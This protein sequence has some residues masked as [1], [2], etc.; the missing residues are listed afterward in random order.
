[1]MTG[2]NN[3]T[4]QNGT[5]KSNATS[6]LLFTQNGAGN[7]T[8]SSV[9]ADGIGNSPLAKTGTGTLTLAGNNTYTGATT[10]RGGILNLT[11]SLALQNSALDTTNSVPGTASAG[12]KTSLT[13]LTLGGLTGSKDLA[14]LFTTSNGGYSSVGNLTLNPSTGVDNL[15]AGSIS[16]GTANLTLIKNGNG[17]QTLSGNST[18]AGL[19]ISAGSMVLK[20]GTLNATGNG[21]FRLGGNSS[22]SFTIDGGT[23]LTSGNTQVGGDVSGGKGLL[24]INNGTWTNSVGATYLGL[25]FGGNGTIMNVNGG[26]VSSAN[27]I[28]IGSGGNTTATLNLNGGT[29]SVARLFNGN[30][31]TAIVNLNGGILK[32]T[33][34]SGNFTAISRNGTMTPL[35][36]LAG[37][38]VLDTNGFDISVLSPLVAGSPSGGLTKT[39]NGTLTLSGNNTYTGVTTLRAG[40]LSVST[41]GDGGVLGN[42][43]Q[44]TSAASNL[45]FAGGGLSYT[46][47]N[48]SS[49]RSFTL[50][51]TDNTTNTIGVSTLGTTLTL[52]GNLPNTNN[53]NSGL[54]QKGGNGTLVLDPGAGVNYTL[55]SLSANGG[56]LT[57]KS[58]NFTTT[59][60]DMTILN[61][62]TLYNFAIGAGARNGGTLVVDGATLNVSTGSLKPGAN[63]NGNL[64]IVSGTVTAPQIWVGHG[65]SSVATQSGGDV[66]TVNLSHSDSGSG[67]YTM[68]G[69]NL[70]VRSIYNSSSGANGTF[71]FAMNGGTLRAREGT[72]NLM[73][74]GGNLTRPQLA[75]HLGSTGARID[76][77]LSNATIQRPLENMSGQ[78]GTLTKIGTNT[79]TLSA[80]NTYTG[81]TT[82]SAGT[83]QIDGNNSGSGAVNIASG[84][85]LGGSG[86]V[87]GHVTV[88]PGGFVAPGAGGIGTLTLASATLS[89]TYQ[90]ELTSTAS[91]LLVVQVLTVDSSTNIVFS[92]APTAD[93]YTIATYGGDMIGT[94]PAITPPSD[95]QLDTATRGVIKLVRNPPTLLANTSLISPPSS[96]TDYVITGNVTITNDVTL[97]ELNSLFIKTATGAS[98][99]NLGT[100]KTAVINSGYLTMTG[101]NNFTIQNGTLKSGANSGFPNSR[102]VVTQDGTGTFTVSSVIANG[103]GNSTLT[104]AGSGTLTLAGAN[105]YTGETTISGGILNLTNSLALQNSPLDA[106][107]SVSGSA[108]A[109]LKTTVSTLTLG[110]LT[111]HKNFASLFTTIGGGY[112]GVTA[113]TL[114][115]GDGVDNTY[116]GI[117]AN[118][119][120][121]MRLIKSGNG[122]LALL[123]SNTYTGNTTISSGILSVEEDKNLGSSG[124]IV[125]A[126]GTLQ[127]VGER[128]FSSTRAV[129]LLANS[130]I[131]VSN[132]VAATTL[133]GT[134]T[135]SANLT[136]TKT[137]SGTL[138]LSG[139]NTS[140]TSTTIVSGGF[141][142]VNGTSIAD[143]GRLVISGGKVNL[144]GNE[145]VG[146]LYFYR[147]PQSGNFTYNATNSSAYFT[148]T[149]NLRVTGTGA[150]LIA[151]TSQ[152]VTVLKNTEK[153]IDLA[154]TLGGNKTYTIVS[155]PANGSLTG[156]PPNMTYHP[157]G[158]YTGP[159]RFT[160]KVNNGDLDSLPATV[161]ITVEESGGIVGT[162]GTTGNYTAGGTNYKVHT[163]TSNG[164]FEVANGGNVRYLVVGGG[165]GGGSA[166]ASEKSGAGGGGGGGGFLTGNL[167]IAP[168]AYPV[169]V[170]AGGAAGSAGFQVAGSSGG[171]SAFA[172]FA[173]AMGGG[174]GAS[175]T[176]S[177][178]IGGSGGG[179]SWGTFPTGGNGTDS[180][181]Y[182]GGNG[183]NASRGYPAGGGGG[184]GGVGGYPS[185]GDNGGRGGVGLSST[186][187]GSELYYADGGGGG[188]YVNGQGGVG[189]FSGNRT[190]VG[191]R[192]GYNNNHAGNGTYSTGG[193]GGG[194]S[195]SFN[196][197]A[198]GSGIVIIS[199]AIIPTPTIT[200][201]G[202]LTTPLSTTYGTA[203]NSGNFTVT[204][205]NM[206]T[207]IVVTAPTGLE[208]S[209]VSS[210][211][212]APSITVGAAGTIDPTTVYVRLA[213][214]ARASGS[215]NSRK[216]LLS[217]S[218]ASPVNVLTSPDGNMV[219]RK[220]L[221]ITAQNRNKGYGAV[222]DS[223]VTVSSD[224]SQSSQ[225]FTAAG[226]VN[227][228][229]VAVTMAYSNGALQATDTVGSSSTITPSVA[230][231]GTLL[232]A[233]YNYAINYVPA[234]LT[235]VG[236][237][238]DSYGAWADTNG[239]TGAAAADANQ[240][241][242]PNGIAYFMGET[243]RIT[244][245]SIVLDDEG[246]YTI[247]WKNGGNIPSSAYGSKFFVETSSDLVT[248]TVV[249]AS[250]LKSNIAT[251]VSYTIP[252]STV[253]RKT[254]VR[255]KVI[256][257]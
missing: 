210:S 2:A 224:S 54:L 243:G 167:T 95:Y 90:C 120:P 40:N 105:T 135:G 190:S 18:L 159:D 136:L 23:L 185:N 44:A 48:A 222:Q 84:A 216:I 169:T 153:V 183:R 42:L 122:T 75:V 233:D 131:D 83:L 118:G 49:N 71:T 241:G 232:P 238:A 197:G 47:G 8:V 81:I 88:A 103:I 180:Q 20:S 175:P 66:T 158:N 192:G 61:N 3:F 100:D 114:N 138:A 134:I 108:T 137:G 50:S 177:A 123:G 152:S 171:D 125:L 182:A 207:G 230:V 53:G 236:E 162:G 63:G 69:G 254:F 72:I 98:V 187:T 110:G 31:S 174:G 143:S 67:S 199:Y 28:E 234:T 228:E 217:S 130:T 1:M 198:G 239:V 21:A 218:G 24:T 13:S 68:T 173:T 221:T 220:P 225:F 212:Y 111:G 231:G 64:S 172:S 36:V 62:S 227:N 148:G 45:V 109:G 121:G 17:T 250:D 37:G 102:L 208:V 248:W 92:G 140:Y 176:A 32:A 240:D 52:T 60:R 142:A 202:N 151:A 85:S 163:F 235:V 219:Q 150:A 112:I 255:L 87:S 157:S 7:L 253:D 89:G 12:L 145:T 156:T 247:A 201:S 215:Y 27:G 99:W 165:G 56:N 242:V 107:N 164:T 226:L 78:N 35:N 91:D 101:A 127:T 4:I 126:G 154:S 128:A 96:S 251:E 193:G 70:T 104:K 33:I 39:G 229:T 6:G 223:L 106:S 200:S 179:G 245:P 10:I 9:I 43:G 160:F 55:G 59:G 189:G 256:A 203:S 113:L 146:T 209:L 181:G 76:T 246:A 80:T 213:A 196:A 116:R 25:G 82:V 191:G 93:E 124:G 38:A 166:T 22:Q 41:I 205:S 237:P 155:Q 117:I 141:L 161:T 204:G 211:G 184:A 119:A 77:T 57:L 129:S 244:P 252:P 206:T 149:G 14:S 73:T 51:G 257:D 79:L 97:A 186:I 16:N 26:Q 65:G 133:N 194:A 249:G 29:T 147:S 30:N 214:T 74:T 139:N 178:R 58:G 170:G 144:T 11:N 132:I 19:R 168:G 5:L 195:R 94:L 115:L 34:A 188:T 46:G 15:Y 86:S